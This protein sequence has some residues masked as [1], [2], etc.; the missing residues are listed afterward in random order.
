[1]QNIVDPDIRRSDNSISQKCNNDPHIFKEGKQNSA[2]QNGRDAEKEQ[3][4]NNYLLNQNKKKSVPYISEENTIVK[5]DKNYVHRE[6]KVQ[7]HT[8]NIYHAS[9]I[10]CLKRKSTSKDSLI[11]EEETSTKKSLEEAVNR[12]KQINE[13]I[14]AYNSLNLSLSSCNFDNSDNLGIR[15]KTSLYNSDYSC[16]VD[17]KNQMSYKK[18]MPQ[19][20]YSFVTNRAEGKKG[21]V[22]NTWGSV[23]NEIEGLCR[24]NYSNSLLHLGGNLGS[25]DKPAC[26]MKDLPVGQGNCC[27]NNR[28]S[29]GG[30][31]SHHS[32]DED[33]LED[34]K[35][36]LTL[37]SDHTIFKTKPLKL[38]DLS[39]LHN[40]S[41][42]YNTLDLSNRREDGHSSNRF[43]RNRI[44]YESLEGLSFDHDEDDDNA[45]DDAHVWG[46]MNFSQVNPP[47]KPNPISENNA[48]SDTLRKKTAGTPES[49]HQNCMDKSAISFELSK[50]SKKNVPRNCIKSSELKNC[51]IK[52]LTHGSINRL[53]YVSPLSRT[54]GPSMNRIHCGG[55]GER[56][57]IHSKRHTNERSSHQNNGMEFNSIKNYS[58]CNNNYR[59]QTADLAG[60]KISMQ[61]RAPDAKVEK[62]INHLRRIS[63]TCDICPAAYNC[64]DGPEG[65][66]TDRG[67][68]QARSSYKYANMHTL[69]GHQYDVKKKAQESEAHC[70]SSPRRHSCLNNIEKF[71]EMLLTM[72]ADNLNEYAKC[73]QSINNEKLKGYKYCIKRV[74]DYN[75]S[76]YLSATFR[77]SIP[78]KGI[79]E[80]V[81]TNSDTFSSV[82]N[83]TYEDD[84]S[85]MFP[86]HGDTSCEELANVSIADGDINSEYG[87]A[88]SVHGSDSA[89][90]CVSDN[91][92][93]RS[94]GN[95]K[96]Y[97]KKKKIK[98]TNCLEHPPRGE[99]NYCPDKI[100]SERNESTSADRTDKK[101][102]HNGKGKY[103]Y[104]RSP[105]QREK[106]TYT[107]RQ[108]K[109]ANVTIDSLQLNYID[110][111]A[112]RQNKMCEQQL[113]GKTYFARRSN[114]CNRGCLDSDCSDYDGCGDCA[115][116]SCARTANGQ[117]AQF[118]KKTKECK[119][120]YPHKGSCRGKNKQSAFLSLD[121]DSKNHNDQLKSSPISPSSMCEGDY[122]ELA[123]NNEQSGRKEILTNVKSISNCNDTLMDDLMR[124]DSTNSGEHR[125]ERST[126][127]NDSN[128]RVSENLDDYTAVNYLQE[129]RLLSEDNK[130]ENVYIMR[131]VEEGDTQERTSQ[132]GGSH[133]I[134]E[135]NSS[136]YP[137]AQSICEQNVTSELG[138][139]NHTGDINQSCYTKG[140]SENYYLE[141]EKL[142]ELHLMREKQNNAICQ[143]YEPPEGRRLPNVV[144]LYGKDNS[145]ALETDGR[146]G[147]LP[148]YDLQRDSMSNGD[149]PFLSKKEKGMVE[150][151]N[152]VLSFNAKENQHSCD[153]NR[154]NHK[155]DAE[156]T[157]LVNNQHNCKPSLHW[158]DKYEGKG[159]E[160]IIKNNK[161]RIEHL[162]DSE[163]DQSYVCMGENISGFT[164]TMEDE[165][166]AKENKTPSFVHK[167]DNSFS[168]QN[169]P[170]Y[171]VN[172]YNEEM[173][174]KNIIACSLDSFNEEFITPISVPTPAASIFSDGSVLSPQK[175]NLNSDGSPQKE[176]VKINA[177]RDLPLGDPFQMYYQNSNC[178]TNPMNSHQIGVVNKKSD[179]N[180]LGLAQDYFHKREDTI[181][182]S[183]HLTNLTEGGNYSSSTIPGDLLHKISR[184][185][186]ESMMEKKL[187]PSDKNINIEECR[188]YKGKQT[189]GNIDNENVDMHSQRKGNIVQRTNE[190]VH[191]MDKLTYH[192]VNNSSGRVK[193]DA[194][195][196]EGNGMKEKKKNELHKIVNTLEIKETKIKTKQGIFEITPE[197]KVLFTFFGRSEIK[198]YK[199]VKRDKLNI[200]I[201]KPRKLLFIIEI[202][203]IDIK[204]KD[205]L[206]DD[207]LDFYNLLEEELP[208]SHQVRYE[209]AYD[210]I[211]TLKKHTPK[212]SLTKK[213]FGVYNLMSN[214]STPDF[215]ATLKN[216]MFIDKIEMKN[217]Q[218]M[219]A[220][221]EGNTVTLNVDDL[222]GVTTKLTRH[223][224]ERG[225]N[226]TEE[227]ATKGCEALLRG[228]VSADEQDVKAVL[229]NLELLLKKTGVSIDIVIQNWCNTLQAY[230]QCLDLLTKGNA[231][232]TLRLRKDLTDITARTE[233]HR[234]EIYFSIFPVIVQE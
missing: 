227:D 183:N 141:S 21:E 107:I 96:V 187:N 100:K 115:C 175:G 206:L 233:L 182:Y 132:E 54:E 204:I 218:V 179:Y 139:K 63:N 12:R 122:K 144:S 79:E 13:M 181:Q 117:T 75:I 69:H 81:L 155:M 121:A 188:I 120:K 56:N 6:C 41:R 178:D 212:V 32:Q 172:S 45:G 161:T 5:T 31:S 160:D 225:K 84:E 136:G 198:E 177:E 146:G 51:N 153:R 89:S 210:V 170:S 184:E 102:M 109:L 110:H 72:A 11:N 186:D 205:V 193:N 192:Q 190:D 119:G 185:K 17:Y 140:V 201:S 24:S 191:H 224:R 30:N 62:G 34:Y 152:N 44:L 124:K 65:I 50:E 194:I 46:D 162:Y 9:S 8:D 53:G 111:S 113:A 145:N 209:Y 39:F 99:F 169:D 231:E 106:Q 1:M 43:C 25:G 216:N 92:W 42:I 222:N 142:S 166:E 200:D 47:R 138:R 4:E 52:Q 94:N 213:W 78:V 226:A 159:I 189:G 7:P 71:K 137:F 40:S 85:S 37:D 73:L 214:G 22:H 86:H 126:F 60:T 64:E 230:S 108:C 156:N 167:L 10:N 197:G 49:S 20:N 163:G 143:N 208:K 80:S 174:D 27:E 19:G 196:G 59:R 195:R 127:R 130:C 36:F 150:G 149:F 135:F 87:G 131:N 147:T 173:E 55:N 66:C 16:A 38:P 57:R 133:P 48:K 220:L 158:T 105:K 215:M 128:L 125:S 3:M 18:K 29:G 67:E 74:N 14:A 199:K 91:H 234:R 97:K 103:A 229:L 28:D 154:E 101:Y 207:V 88:G 58:I 176:S 134:A 68:R 129:F 116:Y 61:M 157:P 82:H 165:M 228:M 104:E 221:K 95:L 219:F 148:F 33:E 83:S 232:Y 203:G 211:E 151:G 180:S 171:S 15:K 217:S 77:A 35:T 23:N 70:N 76:Q 168:S 2:S 114:M 164:R 26:R 118:S 123:P 90:D 98:R 93:H 223:L 112:K 202:N